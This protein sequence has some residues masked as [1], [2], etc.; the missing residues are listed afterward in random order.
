MEDKKI[1]SKKPSLK[2]LAG[3]QIDKIEEYALHSSLIRK[4]ASMVYN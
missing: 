1:T 2:S 3:K 4:L